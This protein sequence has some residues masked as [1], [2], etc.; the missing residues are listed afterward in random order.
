MCLKP[1]SFC[2]LIENLGRRF[3][4]LH[5]FTGCTLKNSPGLTSMFWHLLGKMWIIINIQLDL[6]DNSFASCSFLPEPGCIGGLFTAQRRVLIWPATWPCDYDQDWLGWFH[7]Q[8]AWGSS[9]RH[10]A[11]CQLHL[12]QL[13]NP[14]KKDVFQQ[15]CLPRWDT[16]TFLTFCCW[17]D[18][19][20]TDICEHIHLFLTRPKADPSL[21]ILNCFPLD[22][23]LHHAK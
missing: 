17:Y 16:K 20:V 3:C 11:Q 9:M 7:S 5:D 19:T 23:L 14:A 18:I 10:W 12:R 8:S 6:K 15:V 13:G 4:N 1:D 2:F 22:W 21:L